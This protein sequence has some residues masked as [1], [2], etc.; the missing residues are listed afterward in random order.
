MKAN[1]CYPY[2]AEFVFED[3]KFNKTLSSRL[4]Y[5][6]TAIILMKKRS[7]QQIGFGI[8]NQVVKFLLC[9]VCS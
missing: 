8:E 6:E 7:T 1:A 3:Q 2:F 9:I 4:L 5:G